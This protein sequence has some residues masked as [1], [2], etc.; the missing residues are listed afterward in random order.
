MHTLFTAVRDDWHPR[1]TERLSDPNAGAMRISNAIAALEEG[2][3]RALTLGLDGLDF[4]C[5]TSGVPSL[6]STTAVS[7]NATNAAGQDAMLADFSDFLASIRRLSG[8]RFRGPNT[9]LTSIRA[10]DVMGD[11]FAR[12]SGLD[13]ATGRVLDEILRR[14]GAT[15]LTA[16]DLTDVGGTNV[17]MMVGYSGGERGNLARIVGMRA[18]PVHNYSDSQGNITIYALRTGGLIAPM[19][20]GVHIRYVNF[21]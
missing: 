17:D 3:D 2:E 5:L 11:K 14:K 6:V 18:V 9:V 13:S 20:G 10:Q 1:M 19:G 21:A 12:T 16:E 15:M 7:Y 4:W 8:G